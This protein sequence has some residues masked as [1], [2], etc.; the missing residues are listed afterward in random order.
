M[1]LS[2]DQTST[3]LYLALETRREDPQL[4]QSLTTDLMR[5]TEDI[6]IMDLSRY[7]AYWEKQSAR[8]GL[9]PLGMWRKLLNHLLGEE[10]GDASGKVIT[11]SP[12]YR[13]CCAHN[14]WAAVLLLQAMR[15]RGIKGI[16]SLQG[17]SGHS[18]FKEISWTTWWQ[19]ID[20]LET[21]LTGAKIK[22]Y[23]QAGFR[24]QCKRLSMAIPRLD[25]RRPW[26]MRILNR[27]G[28]KKRFGSFLAD[29]WEWS[30]GGRRADADTVYSIGFPWS[31]HRFGEPPRIR[32]TL[33]YPLLL[34]EQF[35]PLLMED[36]D[37]LCQQ[38]RNTG[39]RITRIDWMLTFEEMSRLRVP[40]L[41]RNPHNLQEEKGDHT[42]PLLQASYGFTEAVNERFPAD[43]DSND[44]LPLVVAWE[45]EITSRLCLPNIILDI[46][47]NEQEKGKELEILLRLE[48]ELPV[49]L[50]RFSPRVDWFPED[51]FAEEHF[52]SE[53]IGS[54]HPESSR[55]LKALA[56]QRPLFIRRTP[57][58]VK[59]MRF[60][61]PER[62]LE[63]TM[64]KW[65]QSSQPGKRERTYFKQIDPE[66]NALWVFRDNA[67]EWYQH[68]VFG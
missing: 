67:G 46:F 19:Q 29:I 11:L 22:G 37:R 52:V 55:S 26:S 58:P 2:Q 12:S 50:S 68:G 32:R 66:G 4:L 33:D 39:E 30:Y 10:A 6:W 51:S 31:A 27:E 44:T 25:F 17:Q 8:A 41:F 13:A 60:P 56:E 16:V 43:P 38:T 20:I 36:F 7:M 59:N 65:W 34:W 47:G 42:T 57:L 5:W 48:N 49:G 40:I 62:F 24:Q 15:E 9:H 3:E 35:A 54:S 63:S 53:E 18:L 61:G 45:L 14:P 64:A 28:V 1:I 23:K 21:H